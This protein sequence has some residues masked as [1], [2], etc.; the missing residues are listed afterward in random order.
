MKVTQ[1]YNFAVVF[2][3]TAQHWNKNLNTTTPHKISPYSHTEAFFNCQNC[4]ETVLLKINTAASLAKVLC[5]KCRL[6][7]TKSLVPISLSHPQITADWAKENTVKP[8]YRSAGSQQIIL[9][10]CQKCGDETKQRID[11][12]VATNGCV[13]C[14]ETKTKNTDKYKQ[15]AEFYVQGNSLSQTRIQ[16]KTT[17]E[18]IKKALAYAN[19]NIRPA[20]HYNNRQTQHKTSLQQIKDEIKKEIIEKYATSSATINQLTDEYNLTKRSAEQL[21][22]GVD[23]IIY[24]QNKYQAIKLPNHPRSNSTGLVCIHTLVAE[25]KLGRPISNK[26]QIHHIDLNKNNN[27]PNN[28]AVGSPQNHGLWH[29]TMYQ[30]LG[31]VLPALLRSGIVS[32]TE[33]QGYSVDV[34]LLSKFEKK[35]I[36]SQRNK[37]VLH[38]HKVGGP[39]TFQKNDTNF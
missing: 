1:D 32:F 26:E 8:K 29:K 16:F 28:L 31:V 39:K 35:F 24:S 13:K 25:Q 21:L 22:L 19:I 11:R 33:K 27:H 6:F 5:N 3:E 37:K 7:E 15:I 9:W 14:K 36:L 18:T 12:R 4:G 10:R 34:K 38:Q 30:F 23:R 20:E 17:N 2:P